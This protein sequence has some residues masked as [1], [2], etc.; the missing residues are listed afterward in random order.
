MDKAL[1][2]V[3]RSDPVL[4]SP[5]RLVYHLIFADAE[6]AARFVIRLAEDGE[7]E[8]VL[9]S[10]AHFA[11][12]AHRLAS[13]PNFAISLVSDG[14]FLEEL[15]KSLGTTWLEAQIRS[16][17]E[18]YAK[19]IEAGEVPKDFLNAHRATLTA[20]VATLEYAENRAQLE[21]LIQLA[22]YKR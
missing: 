11:Y 3:N 4:L 17:V 10:L 1:E 21:E 22:L 2:L 6:F 7:D 14:R 8:L 13:A 18:L 9:E 20:A 15:L 19:R 5:A 16:V 12:D